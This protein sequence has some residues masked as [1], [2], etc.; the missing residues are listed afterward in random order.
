MKVPWNTKSMFCVLLWPFVCSL[1]CVYLQLHNT[2]LDW[3]YLL[4][5]TA[6]TGDNFGSPTGCLIM[7]FGIQNTVIIKS[8]GHPSHRIFQALSDFI[9]EMFLQS[10]NFHS[11]SLN[12]YCK[13]LAELRPCVTLYNFSKTPVFFFIRHRTARLCMFYSYRLG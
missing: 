12:S 9:E 8:P 13:A 11:Q 1:W 3:W 10:I 6:K 5:H 4:Y 7:N 2:V